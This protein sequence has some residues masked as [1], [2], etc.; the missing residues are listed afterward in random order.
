MTIELLQSKDFKLYELFIINN[1]SCSFEHTLLWQKILFKNFGF[2]PYCI[3]SKEFDKINGSLVLLKAKSI[4]GTRFVSTPYSIY[5]NIL[6]DNEKIK[7]SLI[8]YAKNITMT[9]NASFLELREE[10]SDN[11]FKSYGFVE[12]KEVYNFSLELCKDIEKVWKKLPKGSVRWGIKKANKSGLTFRKGN[13]H[14]DLKI[15]YK[16]YL[17]TRKF[18]G[19]PGYPF[20]YFCDIVRGFSNDVQ[21][22]TAYLNDKPIA[23]I[24]LIYYKNEMRYAFSGT[25]HD[26]KYL[27]MQPYHLVFW[28]AIKEACLK[29][30]KIFNLGGATLQTNCGGL[31]GFKKKW[32]DK[33]LVVNNY[34]YLNKIDN[35]PKTNKFIYKVAGGVFKRLPLVV[36]DKLGGKLI[37][38]FV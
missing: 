32:S 6:A 18:R 13:G 21:I 23:S 19:V 8:E 25:I 3:V 7:N 10:L 16:L 26:K 35:V 9:H 11:N 33:V 2:K 5:T 1:D 37:K 12:S 36:I 22:Y 15:F 14:D 34:F 20:S 27:K 4:F 28:Q 31:Y 29:G 24:F 17:N 30:Y 38:Q